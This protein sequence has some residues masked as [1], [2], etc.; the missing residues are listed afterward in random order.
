M[1][2]SN[3]TAPHTSPLLFAMEELKSKREQIGTVTIHI[4]DG[5]HI[6][7]FLNDVE[8]QVLKHWNDSTDR[9]QS[10]VQATTVDPTHLVEKFSNR[11]HWT[12]YEKEKA[13][14]AV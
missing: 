5:E 9:K 7:S 1:A 10:H 13:I 6:S 14:F 2:P 4:Q 3:A 11:R 8:T 12:R